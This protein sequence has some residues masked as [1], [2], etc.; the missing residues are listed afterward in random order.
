[1]TFLPYTTHPVALVEPPT[2]YW[3]DYYKFG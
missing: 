2:Y 3:E 1:V